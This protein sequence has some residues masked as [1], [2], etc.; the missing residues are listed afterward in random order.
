MKMPDRIEMAK[1]IRYYL[2]N[3]EVT[4]MEYR[5]RHPLPEGG[6]IVNAPASRA[7]P[8]AADSLGVHPSQVKDAM[9]AATALGVPTEYTPDGS[10]V[11]RSREHQKQF[12]QA[13]GFFNRD[14]NWSGGNNRQPP[15]PPKKRPRI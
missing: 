2:D 7:Y 3:C 9:A 5:A 8:Y 4:E 6:G 12:C 13:N 11:W 14:E 1:A 15:P 10:I